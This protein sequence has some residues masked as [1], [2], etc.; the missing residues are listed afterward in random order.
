[1]S[2]DTAKSEQSQ[3]R[4]V[5]SQ[6]GQ[7]SNALSTRLESLVHDDGE[8]GLPVTVYAHLDIYH[9]LFQHGVAGTKADRSAAR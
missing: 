2:R 8:Q 5:P 9:R 1:M 6:C 7:Q 3:V 4:F